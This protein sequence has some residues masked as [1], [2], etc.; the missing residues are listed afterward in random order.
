MC[1]LRQ[2]CCH[3]F[4]ISFNHSFSY[5]QILHIGESQFQSLNSSLLN[6]CCWIFSSLISFNEICVLILSIFASPAVKPKQNHRFVYLTIYS[7]SLF[8]FL[9]NIL[10]FTY[11][12]IISSFPMLNLLFPVFSTSVSFFHLFKPKIG[13]TFALCSLSQDVSYLSVFLVVYIR[14]TLKF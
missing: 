11:P 8:G 10:H 5:F 4:S 7:T 14:N 12:K 9:I 13:V 3:F 6:V 2:R 1:F